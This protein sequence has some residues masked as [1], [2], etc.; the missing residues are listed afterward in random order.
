MKIMPQNKA[1]YLGDFSG[2]NQNMSIKDQIARKKQLHQ[3][4]AMH[5][6][7][8]VHKSEMKLDGNVEKIREN[9]RQLQDKIKS[10][11]AYLQENRQKMAQAKEDYDVADDS[12]E[13]A[14]L[15]L[16]MK[17]YDIEKHGSSAGKLTEEEEKRLENMG[18]QTE[19]QKLAMEAYVNVDFYKTEIER[20]NLERY[21]SAFVVRMIDLERLKSHGMVDAEKSAEELMAAASDGAISM[22]L[23]DAKETLD[24]KA[25]ETK[26]SAEKQ[27]EKE[28]ELEKRIEAA[29]ENRA[30]AE[31]A[32]ENAKEN[33][34]SLTEQALTS[35]NMMQDIEGEV[36]KIIEEQKLLEEEIKGIL[37]S[38]QM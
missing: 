16:L 10:H 11:Q 26:E 29:R 12:Q 31:A 21:A 25:E 3:K 38:A 4:E 34:A 36:K 27:N 6:V 22:L 35:D 1:V 19:Y 18:E 17:A 9:I 37:I 33:A 7:S 23:D 30:E 28:E 14:D 24:T 15:E 20:N 13:Q 8:T 2:N 32:A 5:T